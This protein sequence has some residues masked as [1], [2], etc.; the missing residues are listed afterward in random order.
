[1]VKSNNS[2][3]GRSQHRSVIIETCQ[4]LTVVIL[5]DMIIPDHGIFWTPLINHVQFCCTAVGYFWLSSFLSTFCDLEFSFGPLRI[6]RILNKC[7]ISIMF[8]DFILNLQFVF[9]PEDAGKAKRR[10]IKEIYNAQ[11]FLSSWPIMFPVL[12]LR[13]IFATHFEIQLINCDLPTCIQYSDG[14]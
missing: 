7:T 6:I 11:I 4:E 14:S 10:T 2:E 13:R 9:I 3:Y 8:N 1:M 5:N 12:C